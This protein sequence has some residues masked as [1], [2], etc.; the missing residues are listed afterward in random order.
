MK[1]MAM[2]RW[3]WF[4]ASLA[5]LGITACGDDDDPGGPSDA[6]DAGRTDARTDTRAD[7]S[8]TPD[9]R[10]DTAAP[11]TRDTLT[12]SDATDGAARPDTAGDT[13]GDGSSPVQRGEYLVKNV[14]ACADC[15]TPINVMTGQPDNT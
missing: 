7:V 4:G 6:G 5:V 13:G 14:G 8:P 12:P 3:A 2:G 15:H 11:D 9:I 10:A 1:A